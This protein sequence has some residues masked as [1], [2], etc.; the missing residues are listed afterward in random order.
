MTTHETTLRPV[1]EGYPTVTPWIISKDTAGVLDFLRQAFGAEELARVHNPDGSIGHAETRIGDAVVMLFDGRPDWPDTPCFL[2]LYLPDGDA[3]FERAVAAGGTAVTRMTELFWGDRV[4]R[5]R[6]P[7]G[8]LYWIHT[9]VAEP[10]AA[11]LQ[12]RMVDPEFVA[13]ME[14]V[15]SGELVPPS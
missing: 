15:Q 9:R 5:V 3:A 8:N 11:E 12:R 1:P 10:D 6:D 7:F 13:A 4:G 14:Y 2:R